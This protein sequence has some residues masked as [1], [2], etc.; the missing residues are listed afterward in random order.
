MMELRW[1][2]CNQS[3]RVC[4]DNALLQQK[5]DGKW[6]DIPVVDGRNGEVMKGVVVTAPWRGRK[7][8]ISITD[9]E[10]AQ[11]AERALE[12]EK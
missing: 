6:V 3:V 1:V 9:G 2:R 5:V 12:G 4:E 11:I 8:S 10:I 7:N